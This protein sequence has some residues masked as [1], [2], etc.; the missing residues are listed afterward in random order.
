M[1][2][3]YGEVENVTLKEGVTWYKQSEGGEIVESRFIEE[4][5]KGEVI[6][7]E[8]NSEDN[9]RTLYDIAFNFLDGQ[10]KLSVE[11]KDME[12]YFIIHNI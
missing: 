2:Y 8:Y 1:E 3:K 11:E 7:M 12:L 9:S 5:T 10:V 6:G 4:G